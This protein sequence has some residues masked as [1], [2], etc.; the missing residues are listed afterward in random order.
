M[1]ISYFREP[2]DSFEFLNTT[3]TK[4]KLIEC[5]ITEMPDLDKYNFREIDLER[6]ELRKI[7]KL[8]GCIEVLNLSLNKLVGKIDLSQYKSIRVL[9]IND[10]KLQ[11]FPKLPEGV[12]EVDSRFNYFKV[13]HHLPDSIEKLL[14]SYNPNLEKFNIPK[15]LRNLWVYNCPKLKTNEYPNNINLNG[16]RN[17]VKPKEIVYKKCKEEHCLISYDSFNE[18]CEFVICNYCNVE[19]LYSSII[20][21]LSENDECPHCRQDWVFN[22]FLYINHG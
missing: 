10:N 9:R 18:N 1:E 2:I 7:P 5:G 14:L 4:L 17:I 21:W 8:P 3:A 20:V 13:I 6:N 11:I 16:V 15:S 22:D 12:K 19:Y